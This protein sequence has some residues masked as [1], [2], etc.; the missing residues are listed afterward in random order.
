[1]H[2]AIPRDPFT[3]LVVED[4]GIIRMNVAD[5]LQDRGFVVIEAANAAEA[6]GAMGDSGNGIDLVFSDVR[7]PGDMD[8]FALA[9]WLAKHFAHVPVILTSGDTGKENA[10]RAF[11]GSA[12]VAKPYQLHTVAQKISDALT[13]R[14]A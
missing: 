13:C 4:E 3:I 7:M 5:F 9:T 8:G 2:E 14:A 12:F 11:V 1:V 6:V 10:R